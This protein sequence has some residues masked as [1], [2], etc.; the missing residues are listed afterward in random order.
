MK[1]TRVLVC[2][3]LV[4]VFI[5]AVLIISILLTSSQKKRKVPN[6]LFIVADD[7]GW[8]DVSWHNKDII[9]PNL[10]QLAAQGV[11]L[12]QSYVQ[13]MCTPSRAAFLTGQYP[14][15]YGL[16]H[17]VFGPVE[18]MGLPLSLKT[19]GQHLK[20]LGYNTHLMGK[21]HLGYCSR[22]YTPTNR[23]FDSFIGFY[24]GLNAHFTHNRTVEFNGTTYNGYNLHE[25]E[26]IQ[27]RYNGTY[28]TY[29]YAQRAI[30][31]IKTAKYAPFFI[32]LALQSPHSPLE[33]PKKY[34]DM[35]PNEKNIARRTYSGMVTA[36]DETVG[37]VIKTLKQS[38]QYDNTLIVFT[39]DNGGENIYGGNNWPLRGGK[40]TIWEGGTRVVGFVHSPLL[41]KGVILATNQGID[42]VDQWPMISKDGPSARNEIIY[43]IDNTTVYSAAIRIDDYKL[44]MGDAGGP[45][46]WMTPDNVIEAKTSRKKMHLE[47]RKYY[48]TKVEW[49]QLYNLK[50][51][52]CETTNIASQHPQIVKALEKRLE[53]LKKHVVP[54]IH[55]PLD[56]NG[57]PQKWSATFS[58]GWCQA[59]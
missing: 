22:E 29:L 15:R 10:Y 26:T 1:L 40:Q 27:Y 44:I 50:I 17:F 23:G 56:T 6:I 9:T 42:G 21:W 12:N 54:N 4:V 49:I 2:T 30:E 47:W 38:G 16:Q 58:P 20:L 8:N 55:L 48:D 19:L 32:F 18:P 33:V 51:D 34:F 3:F 41:K 25:N 13:P 37:K 46:V 7:L 5:V 45:N 11:I 24:T 43:N 59:V 31:V 39:S 28:S 35:Y 57:L 53:E 14:F 36:M 52:P